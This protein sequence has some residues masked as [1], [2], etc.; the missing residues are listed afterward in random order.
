MTA[1]ESELKNGDIVEII[2]NKNAKPNRKWLEHAKTTFAK[3][4]IKNFN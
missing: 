2:I 4:H 1:L 3:K